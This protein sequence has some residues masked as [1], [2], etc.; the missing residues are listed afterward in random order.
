MEHG[1]VR[2]TM[3]SRLCRVLPLFA[4]IVQFLASPSWGAEL[5]REFL[6]GLRA[7]GLHDVAIDY[8]ESLRSSSL[9]PDD[10]RQ[11]LAY[12][13]G[14]T[15]ADAAR[16]IRDLGKR[17]SEL[18]KAAEKLIE[19]SGSSP[20]HSLQGL[21]LLRLGRI[22]LIL[23]DGE[24]TLAERESAPKEKNDRLQAA[25]DWFQKARESF[26]QAATA[27]EGQF[28]SLGLEPDETAGRAQ[29]RQAILEAKL[30]VPRTIQREADAISADNPQRAER[31]KT[32]VDG[33]VKLQDEYGRWAVAQHALVW[34][35]ECLLELGEPRKAMACLDR[36]LWQLKDAASADQLTAEAT[37]LFQKA[38]LHPQESKYAEA[39]EKGQLFLESLSQDAENSAAAAVRYR[40]AI[41]ASE[42]VNQVPN[43]RDR[44]R[45]KDTA[46]SLAR[47]VSAQRG[48]YQ[49]AARELLVQLGGQ[50]GE[51]QAKAPKTFAEAK[52]KGEVSRKLWLEAVGDLKDAATEDEIAP[53]KEQRTAERE[54]AIETYRRAL[55]LAEEATPL[56]EINEVRLYLAYLYW[57]ANRYEEAAI[58]GD[59]LAA[60]Y[61]E[62]PYARN[63]ARLALSAYQQLIPQESE[64]GH[65]SISKRMEE[66]SERMLTAW[67]DQSEAE[68]AVLVLIDAAAQ[69]GDAETVRSYINRFFTETDD[70]ELL[71]KAGQL[72][73][74]G[75]LSNRKR[76]AETQPPTDVLLALRNTA[77]EILAKVVDEGTGLQQQKSL[78]SAIAL[79]QLYLESAKPEQALDVVE[80][81]LFGL[82]SSATQLTED[83]DNERLAFEACKVALRTYLSIAP[84]RLDAATEI[85]QKLDTAA[86]AGGGT[87]DGIHQLYLGLGL[88]M[89]DHIESARQAGDAARASRMAEGVQLLLTRVSDKS[90]AAT[91]SWVAGTYYQLAAAIANSQGDEISR[92][93][94]AM[95]GGAADAY[96]KLLGSTPAPEGDQALAIRL[97]MSECLRKS[98]NYRAAQGEVE[99]V[100]SS[101]PA[102]VAA[103]IEAA[104]V[105]Q[106]IGATG[107][108]ESLR[109]AASG[110][111]SIWG[112]GRLGQIT[113]RHEELEDS[114]FESRYE[115][116]RCRLAMARMDSAAETRQLRLAKSDILLLAR[117]RSELASTPWRQKFDSLYKEIQRELGESASGLSQVFNRQSSANRLLSSQ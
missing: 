38:A 55:Q 77:Q 39:W 34:Q 51:D 9:A 95:F 78:A 57:D 42:L 40:T 33:Y 66:L 6:D 53:L 24:L 75:Y 101:K 30:M 100:L 44:R 107:D 20:G 56:E 17:Q 46:I 10:L 85:M 7:R 1:R 25:M 92:D 4:A 91:L 103:Q 105:L 22:H 64:S 16:S 58:L 115:L 71:A 35:G 26:S 19:F 84:P 27:A 15:I 114:F 62:S 5:A 37:V 109:Q 116:A 14:I 79:A 81:H 67:P 87:A 59:F 2:K 61:P 47:S 28:A 63:A 41:A 99:T 83:G 12:E 86:Q 48:E 76:P 94:S 60:K 29:I 72:L 65:R 50:R 43:V 13:E 23:G 102:L 73:W 108:M 98:G 70:L 89:I 110:S 18:T 90:D 113:A 96:K 11:S 93:A 54:T 117:T 31:L 32:A 68:T 88:E 111:G 21:A 49:Q 52:Q 74:N 97:R 8:I 82:T 104:R 3:G 112:W 106:A 45:F 80:G 69:R 36:A